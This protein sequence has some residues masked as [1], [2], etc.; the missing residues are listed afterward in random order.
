MP[1]RLEGIALPEIAAL[2]AASEPSHALR[3][4]AVGEAIGNDVALCLLLHAVVADGAGRVQPFFDIVDLEE[5]ARTVGMIGPDPREAIG[6]KLEAHR[7]SVGLGFTDTTACRFHLFHDAKQVLHVVTDF[8]RD[9]IRLGEVTGGSV[10]GFQ[11]VVESEVDVYLPVQRTIERSRSRL[12][13]TAGG[14]CRAGEEDELG[15]L[16]LAPALFEDSAPGVLGVREHLR[17]EHGHLVVGRRSSPGH[18]L[19]SRSAAAREEADQHR[20]V[21]AKK[22]ACHKGDDECPDAD[23]PADPK[24]AAANATFLAAVLNIIALSLVIKPHMPFLQFPTAATE[25]TPP[26]TLLEPPSDWINI[27]IEK[28]VAR[29]SRQGNPQNAM[30][31]TAVKMKTESG[32][33]LKSLQASC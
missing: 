5:V 6:L 23:A 24:A 32:F 13:G 22:V 20:R 17:D 10:A 14:R 27:M 4:T 1:P 30:P 18:R 12:A 33:Q 28:M 2:E 16:V 8:V 7:Q 29:L 15:I 21:D 9:H 19:G 31:P 3:R 25:N 11:I 26:W